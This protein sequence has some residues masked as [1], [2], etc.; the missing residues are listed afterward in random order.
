MTECCTSLCEL[1]VAAN[2]STCSILLT[3]E[4]GIF[5]VPALDTR[6]AENKLK[7]PEQAPCKRFLCEEKNPNIRLI[8]PSKP[9]F[10]NS[11]LLHMS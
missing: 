6:T 5:T 3:K 11:N 2:H 8:P 7:F 10:P 1:V 9:S 4:N